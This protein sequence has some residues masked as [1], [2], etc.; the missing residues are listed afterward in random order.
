MW[1]FAFYRFLTGLGVGG[2][3][4]GQ[5]ERGGFFDPDREEGS[6]HDQQHRGVEQDEAAVEAHHQDEECGGHDEAPESAVDRQLAH[7][8]ETTAE[9]HDQGET[10][11]GAAEDQADGDAG[12]TH[13]GGGQS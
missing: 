12:L 3:S 13:D 2:E 1:D 7:A 4:R 11:D 10:R 8:A 5:T 9:A 6:A